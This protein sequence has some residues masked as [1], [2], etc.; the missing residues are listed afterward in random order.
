MGD[1]YSAN[2]TDKNVNQYLDVCVSKF[3]AFL[4]IVCFV[5]VDSEVALNMNKKEQ[6]SFNTKNNEK[7]INDDFNNDHKTI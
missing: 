7:M 1:L 6:K 4:F 3:F 2:L 5:M